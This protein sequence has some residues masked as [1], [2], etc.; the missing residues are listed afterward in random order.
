MLKK[1]QYFWQLSYQRS[2]QENL[3]ALRKKLAARLNQ[4]KQQVS[5]NQQVDEANTL[6]KNERFPVSSSMMQEIAL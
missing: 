1:L 6:V 4:N 3:Q 2:P 5:T